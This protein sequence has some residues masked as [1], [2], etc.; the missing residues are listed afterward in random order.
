[1]K[2]SRIKQ[3]SWK[4]LEARRKKRERRR[5]MLKK[6]G[7]KLPRLLPSLRSLRLKLDK[8]FSIYIRRRFEDKHGRVLCVTCGDRLHWKEANA[9]H[10][11]K[12]QFL[13]TRYD[14]RNCHVQCVRCNLYR[15]GELI[16]YY[17]FMLHEYGPG[18]VEELKEMKDT[19]A[20]FTRTDLMAMI[21][22]YVAIAK[23]RGWTV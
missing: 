9:G 19:T 8:L 4:E 18:V 7:L 2:R 22:R 14:E 11:I 16:E 5:R 12:R 1:M 17:G 20:K 21:D 10:F 23:E 15:G 3:R 6:L 13:A